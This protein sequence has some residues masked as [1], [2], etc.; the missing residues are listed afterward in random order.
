MKLPNSIGIC[1]MSGNVIE[2]CW[3]IYSGNSARRVALGGGAI[4]SYPDNC[5][6][7]AGDV[8]YTITK[9]NDIGFRVVRNAD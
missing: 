3:D 4:Y 8:V 6:V 2:L 1:D 7:D 9:A 5:A